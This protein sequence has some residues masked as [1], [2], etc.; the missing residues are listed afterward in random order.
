M[1]IGLQLVYLGSSGGMSI[2]E[3]WG[4]SCK[5]PASVPPESSDY[6]KPYTELMAHRSDF[7]RASRHPNRA[8]L[9]AR[10]PSLS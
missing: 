4:A 8:A 7:L 10:P 1:E 9:P 2:L 6:P 3:R 5:C